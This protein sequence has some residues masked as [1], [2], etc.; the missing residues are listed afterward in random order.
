MK[1]KTY[2]APQIRVYQL[3]SENIL[4]GGSTKPEPGAAGAPKKSDNKQ[5]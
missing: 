2:T 5:V 3:L 1:K 4:W